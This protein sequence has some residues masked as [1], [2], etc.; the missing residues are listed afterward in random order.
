MSPRRFGALSGPAA[1]LVVGLGLP[2]SAAPQD[3]PA[4]QRPAEA[5]GTVSAEE[6]E[7]WRQYNSQCARCH[8]QDVLGN[9]VAADLLRSTRPGGAM[10]DRAAFVQVVAQGRP[11]RGMPAFER[12]LTPE[13]MNAIYAYVRGRA[14]G[15]IKP[16]RPARPKS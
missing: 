9:P 10:H 5:A 4:P 11:S 15:R 14:E 1:A 12:I 3:Q 7:G 2:T 16:G 6:Y 8:G 13:Q